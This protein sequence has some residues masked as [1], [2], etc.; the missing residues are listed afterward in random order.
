[1]FNS[2][3]DEALARRLVLVRLEEPQGYSTE[4]RHICV[5]V[6]RRA[7]G[8]KL[9]ADGSIETYYD[10]SDAVGYRLAAWTKNTHG[11]IYVDDL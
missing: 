8:N 7:V 3:A 4:W 11:A 5:N 9:R 6:V 1:M 10:N 2:L